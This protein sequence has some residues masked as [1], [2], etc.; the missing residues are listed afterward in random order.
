VPTVSPETVTPHAEA[1]QAVLWHLLVTHPSLR[2]TD[3]TEMKWES[4]RF[5]PSNTPVVDK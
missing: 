3:V 5:V 1:F 2:V 4:T